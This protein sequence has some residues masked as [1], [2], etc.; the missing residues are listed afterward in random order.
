MEQAT[1]QTHE[2]LSHVAKGHEAMAG[3]MHEL[4]KAHSAP[5]KTKAIRD[6]QGKI[7]GSETV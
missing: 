3:A 2:L 5:R 1:Q 6:N 4:A 7:I